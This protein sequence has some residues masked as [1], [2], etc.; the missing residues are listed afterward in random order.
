[1][2]TIGRLDSKTL[3]TTNKNDLLTT[4]ATPHPWERGY[5]WAAGR[6]LAV[7]AVLVT[8]AGF[9]GGEASSA[10]PPPAPAN[11]AV[12]TFYPVVNTNLSHLVPR[13]IPAEI[14]VNTANVSQGD[15]PPSRSGTGSDEIVVKKLGD[16]VLYIPKGYLSSFLGY[17]GY[18]QIHALLPC[19]LPETSENTAAFHKTGMENILIANLSMWYY[20]NITGEQ[21]LGVYIAN[22]LYAIMNVPKLENKGI[23]FGRIENTDLFL[24]KNFFG[25]NTDIFVRPKPLPLFFFACDEPASGPIAFSP[26]CSVRERIF[27]DNV[28]I[29][30]EK[31]MN[32]DVLLEYHYRRSFINQDINNGIKID[33][34]LR[35]LLDSFLKAPESNNQKNQGGTCQ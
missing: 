26:G 13:G 14:G 4:H 33:E 3:A 32:G 35:S 24:L 28:S 29:H 12:A 27:G 21:L 1:M 2:R 31:K 18:V 34:K 23:Y 10:E 7:F 20:N 15:E 25:N 22:S 5:F 11:V 30:D 9:L 6:V 16:H 8:G 17:S 19:L